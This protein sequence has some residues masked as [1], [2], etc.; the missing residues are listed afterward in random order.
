MIA[1]RPASDSY[2]S[3]Q[4]NNNNPFLNPEQ[5]QYGNA[6]NDLSGNFVPF[7]PEQPGRAPTDSYGSPIRDAS[8]A[9]GSVAGINPRI[10]GNANQLA[11]DDGPRDIYGSPVAPVGTSA[12]V[13]QDIITAA[14]QP[15]SYGSPG[16]EPEGEVTGLKVEG[17]DEND[18]LFDNLRDN[19]FTTA[20]ND[21]PSSSTR[22]PLKVDLSSSGEVDLTNG[23]DQEDLNGSVDLTGND[24][25]YDDGAT[26]TVVPLFP[27]YEDSGDYDQVGTIFLGGKG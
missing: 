18:P 17:G 7:T 15:D 22:S 12:P 20:S 6:N 24:D 14:R 5:S 11:Q 8:L 26:T 2:G 10:N 25:N 16:D 9:S 13:P 21:P 3:P 1:A 19:V 4:N 27:G 23:L